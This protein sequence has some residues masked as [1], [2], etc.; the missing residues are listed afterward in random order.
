LSDCPDVGADVPRR[1]NWETTR[2]YLNHRPELKVKG[3][4]DSSHDF[5]RGLSPRTSVTSCVRGAHG[6]KSLQWVVS[7][8]IQASIE[9]VED[10]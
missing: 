4:S 5:S 10:D 1:M 9:V 8:P 7:S 2:A 3:L 6:M